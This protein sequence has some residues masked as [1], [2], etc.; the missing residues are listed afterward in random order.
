MRLIKKILSL[1]PV[2]V[3]IILCMA[4]PSVHAENFYIQ[5]YEVK[6]EVNEKKSVKVEEE[7]EVCFLKPSHGIIRE[8]PHKKASVTNIRAQ[9]KTV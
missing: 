7:I 4:V 5:N 8:I 3:F 6:L 1:I 9:E 2:P